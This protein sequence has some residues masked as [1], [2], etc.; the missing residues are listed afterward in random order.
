MW[1]G[2]EQV[3]DPTQQFEKG[4]IR[5][6]QEERIRVQQKTFT[7]WINFH[8]K[9]TGIHVEDLFEDIRNGRMLHQLLQVISGEML[10]KV[11]R[12]VMRIQ[13][14]ENVGISLSFLSKKVTLENIGASD[15]VDGN[16][17][18]IL[19][20]I[21][22]IILRFQIQQIVFE[23]QIVQETAPEQ[24]SSVKKSAKESLLLWCQKQ[25]E[26]YD[27]V[28]IRNFDKSWQDGLAFN[29]LLHSRRPDLVNYDSLDPNNAEWNLRHAF[30]SAENEMNIPRLIDPE[31]VVT[32]PDEKSI[33]TYVAQIYSTYAKMKAEKRSGRRMENVVRM[34]M[35]I[36]EAEKKYVALFSDLVF[37]VR[38]K[39]KELNNR[40]FPNS[41]T[42]IQEHLKKFNRY[43]N[44]EKPMKYKEKG[45]LHMMFHSINVKCFA[46]NRIPFY[47]PEGH[48][49][50]NLEA[51]WDVLDR[52]ERE[53]ERAIV[54]EYMRLESLER[55]A[56]R[57]KRKE[58]LRMAWLEDMWEIIED[59]EQCRDSLPVLAA[60]Q[61]NE[62]IL[63]DVQ[64]REEKFAK[65]KELAKFLW[66]SDYHQK[67]EIN[68]R[69]KKLRSEYERLRQSVQAAHVVLK[70]A[71]DAGVVARQTH[72]IRQEIKSIEPALLSQETGSHLLMV[73]D[74]LRRHSMLEGQIVSIDARITQLQNKVNNVVAAEHS[75]SEQTVKS[76]NALKKDFKFVKERS[77]GR[78]KA[79]EQNL[80]LFQFHQDADEE[81]MWLDESSQI[82]MQPVVARDLL[83]VIE[84]QKK[85][86][87]FEQKINTHE[88]FIKDILKRGKSLLKIP[89]SFGVQQRMEILPKKLE[90]LKSCSSER[91]ERLQE[92][93]E[94]QQ[95]Y[96]DANDIES[97]MKE[98]Y[99][100]VSN[101]NYGQDAMSATNLFDAHKKL[102][103]QI[104]EFA[105][106]VS[107]LREDADR[108]KK[109]EL[110]LQPMSGGVESGVADEFIE[111]EVYIPVEIEDREMI[112]REIDHTDTEV[113]EIPRVATLREY[114][115]KSGFIIKAGTQ[116]DLQDSSDELFWVVKDSKTGREMTLP[117]NL[118]R[119]N[120]TRHEEVHVSKVHTVHEEVAV[121]RIQK[122]KQKVK[123]RKTL[124]TGISPMLGEKVTKSSRF[125]AE[126]IQLRQQ[127]IESTYNQ[128]QKL[129]SARL[130][131]LHDFA[132]LFNFFVGAEEL[133]TWI[134]I[135]D[136]WIRS[137]LNQKKDSPDSLRHVLETF[138]TE[139]VANE[140]RV[141][142]ILA[143][144]EK[145]ARGSV[146]ASNKRKISGM[147]SNI[148][149]KW[150]AL[151]KLKLE[152]EKILAGAA[153][154]NAFEADMEGAIDMAK[155]TIALLES[156]IAA[157]KNP[158]AASA[159]LLKH[160]L[161]PEDV[162]A[163]INKLNKTIKPL[164]ERINKLIVLGNSL[165]ST[166]PGQAALVKK[167]VAELQAVRDNLQRLLDER[168]G[169]L[170]REK[171]LCQFKKD[172]ESQISW[173]DKARDIMSYREQPSDLET[174]SD[175]L[176]EHDTL[177]DEIDFRVPVIEEL[178]KE[179]EALK[180]MAGND[181]DFGQL[182]QKVTQLP[183]QLKNEW[184]GR[185]KF[186]KDCKNAAQFYR[187]ADGV[188]AQLG[189]QLALLSSDNLGKSADEVESLLN[190]LN[191]QK[192]KIHLLDDKTKN[193]DTKAAK[194]TR[195]RNVASNKVNEK[196]KE[197]KSLRDKT[198]KAYNE[199][200]RSLQDSLDYQ[201]LL[202]DV[203]E[204][205][206][207]MLERLAI[208]QDPAF[209]E[210]VNLDKKQKIIS[211]LESE[212][213][214]RHTDLN[215]IAERGKHLM[216]Q[217]H[218][219]SPEI[220]Q[221]LLNLAK[222][223]K[224][225]KLAVENAGG[226]IGLSHKQKVLRDDIK[227]RNERLA[228]LE[229]E[230]VAENLGNSLNEAKDLLK[231]NQVI[232]EEIQDG[233]DDAN[234][235]LLREVDTLIQK[236]HH[237]PDGIRKMLS[238]YADSVKNLQRRGGE[239]NLKLKDS[240]EFFQWKE[241]ALSQKE[242][243][244][245]R[246]DEAESTHFGSHLDA[247][248]NLLTRHQ[249]LDQELSD[250][251]S[252]VKELLLG[253][254]K[255]IMANHWAKEQ[256]ESI[257]D[258]ITF[259]WNTINA[260]CVDRM[261]N[262]QSVLQY[263]R[264][265]MSLEDALEWVDERLSQYHSRRDL[266]SSH[267]DK[268]DERKTANALS[269][270]K[271]DEVA[272][273]RYCTTLNDLDESCN[274]FV[275][276]EH[277]LCES[278]KA[279]QNELGD[280]L[281]NLTDELKTGGKYFEA[282]QMAA[283]F[284]VESTELCDWFVEAAHKA[285]SSDF[286][287]DFES[288]EK[289]KIDFNK[290]KEAV[291]MHK[292]NQLR[293]CEQLC[294]K[295]SR[296]WTGD[297]FSWVEEKLDD[298][299]SMMN[300]LEVMVSEREDMMESAGELHKFNLDVVEALSQIQ[301]KQNAI[302]TAPLANPTL[303]GVQKLLRNHESFET[304]LVALEAQLHALV[305]ESDRLSQ[306][307]PG[308]NE[309]SLLESKNIMVNAWQNLK[310]DSAKRKQ[311]L[312]LTLEFQKYKS[313]AKDLIDW[314]S[315]QKRVVSAIKDSTPSAD[316]MNDLQESL[317]GVKSGLK[318]KEE[319]FK[320]LVDRSDRMI[321]SEE[322]YPVD[323][324][325]TDEQID[326]VLNTVLSGK[327]ALEDETGYLDA[328]ITHQTQFFAFL[329]KYKNLK[330]LMMNETQILNSRNSRKVS[331]HDP[332]GS[333]RE[334][335]ALENKISK[336][337][338]LLDDIRKVA[339]ELEMSGHPKVK[340]V[341]ALVSELESTRYQV[342]AKCQARRALLD[343]TVDYMD[344]NMRAAEEE[345]WLK[346]KQ[347]LADND[348]YKKAETFEQKIKVLQKHQ[349]LE[350]EIE[351]GKDRFGILKTD[352]QKV[353]YPGPYA[354]D[355]KS[356]V[357]KLEVLWRKLLES[358]NQKNSVLSE[359]REVVKFF[360]ECDES[361]KWLKQKE[362]LLKMRDL[363][364]DYE[365]CLFILDKLNK[366]SPDEITPQKLKELNKLADSI[367]VKGQLDPQAV[368]ERKNEINDRYQKVNRDMK[369]YTDELKKSLEVHKFIRDS[370]DLNDL[371]AERTS[372]AKS[373]DVGDSL[374]Y[375]Q[376]LLNR[377]E[378]VQKT[379]IPELSSKM[380]NL[381]A[382]GLELSHRQPAREQ[383]V[384]EA[385]Q[386]ANSNWAVLNDVTAQRQK[387]LKNSVDCFTFLH[388]CALRNKWA[389]ELIDSMHNRV[390]PKNLKE[391]DNNFQSHESLNKEIG[392][393]GKDVEVLLQSG[394]ELSSKVPRN[395]D[396]ISQASSEVRDIMH[397]LND[398]WGKTAKEL[399]D[400]IAYQQFLKEAADCDM[401]ITNCELIFNTS[402]VG[403]SLSAVESLLSKYQ[404]RVSAYGEVK[405]Q[406]NECI[407]KGEEI[408]ENG[409]Y[410]SPR[411][412]SRMEELKNKLRSSGESCSRRKDRLNVSK[413]VQLFLQKTRKLLLWVADQDKKALD[414]NFRDP[415]NLLHKIELHSTFE[416]GIKQHGKQ[417]DDLKNTGE[418]LLA[419]SFK[420]NEGI[421]SDE[422]NLKLE[423]EAKIRE[424]LEEWQMLLDHSGD[425]KSKLREAL[426]AVEFNRLAENVEQFADECEKDFE[427]N[428]FGDNL[429]S[430]KRV[431]AK[432]EKMKD[433]LHEKSDNV[434]VL[435]D[436]MESL[437]VSTTCP[438]TA[439][440]QRLDDIV[441]RYDNLTQGA[442]RRDDQL[443]SSLI[444]QTFIEK[445]NAHIKW[446]DQKMLETQF[447][448]DWTKD[449]STN[450]I[451]SMLVAS[452]NL[453]KE[454]ENSQETLT[455]LE[456]ESQILANHHPVH[457]NT[458]RQSFGSY[459][460][461]F[462]RLKQAS[463]DKTNVLRIV[464]TA[465]KLLTRTGET[466]NWLAQKEKFLRDIDSQ[467]FVRDEQS[468]QNVLDQVVHF[469]TEM[470]NQRANLSQ[471]EEDIS[472]VEKSEI[473]P[474]K[475]MF[476]NLRVRPLRE[477]LEELYAYFDK[478]QSLY[479][480]RVVILT[481][482]LN[483]FLFLV[484][485]EESMDELDKAKDVCRNDDYGH[486]VESVEILVGDFRGK[487]KEMI[488]LE[489]SCDHLVQT[490]MNLASEP[491]TLPELTAKSGEL[492]A[493]CQ[494]LK[495]LR[496][497]RAAALE[498]ARLVHKL[499]RDIEDC[500]ASIQ[501]KQAELSNE[502]D[503][504]E[505]ESLQLM[506]DKQ[507]DLE[508]EIE[509][510]NE[511]VNK[512][513]SNGENLVE[514]YG[515]DD[516]VNGKVNELKAEWTKLKSMSGMQNDKL[517][518]LEN[519][520]EFYDMF[521]E[522]MQWI[523]ETITTMNSDDLPRDVPGATLK[524]KQ[525]DLLKQNIRSKD[526]DVK[527]LWAKGQQ[528]IETGVSVQEDIHEKRCRV[529]DGY[530][531]VENTWKQ[532]SDLYKINLDL[533][534][535]LA[536]V[537]NLD[538][539]IQKKTPEVSSKNCGND[540]IEVEDLLKKQKELEELIDA[541][542]EKIE[543]INRKTKLES[544]LAD[545]KEREEERAR[546]E[547]RRK[548]QASIRKRETTRI[549]D[550]RHRRNR[551]Q[552]RRTQE[553]AFSPEK[554][555]TKAV[556][557]EAI[558]S[559]ESASE[560]QKASSFNSNSNQDKKFVS[561][562][563]TDY[564]MSAEAAQPLS[565]ASGMNFESGLSK[566]TGENESGAFSSNP[567]PVPKAP[568]I[569]QASSLSKQTSK[570]HNAS[571]P[572]SGA[573]SPRR[574][575]SGNNAADGT[576]VSSSQGGSTSPSIK[577]SFSPPLSP[578]R[579]PRGSY[580]MQSP[581]LEGQAKIEQ[582][583][584]SMK[585][586]F[587][588]HRMK[589]I[590]ASNQGES[591]LVSPQEVNQNNQ[592]P[593]DAN[594]VHR[595]PSQ[596]S[597]NSYASINSAWSTA[598]FTDANTDSSSSLS[599]SFTGMVERK[600][601]MQS[602]SRKA[603][604]R[605]WKTLYC[606]V[607]SHS[608]KFYKDEH[609][610]RN[611]ETCSSLISLENAICEEAVDYHKKKHT[612]R[613]ITKDG[614]EY[615]F[616]CKNET[617]ARNLMHA[618]NE[619]A[620]RISAMKSNYN[621]THS[622]TVMSGYGSLERPNI[623]PPQPPSSLGATLEPIS[624]SSGLRVQTSPISSQKSQTNSS[625]SD[626]PSPP[627]TFSMLSRN[628]LTN[629]SFRKQNQC[630]EITQSFSSTSVSS[631]GAFAPPLPPK[632]F[633]GQLNSTSSNSWQTHE[634]KE[635][636]QVTKVTS[637]NAKHTPAIITASNKLASI[638]HGSNAVPLSPNLQRSNFSQSYNSGMS[639]NANKNP[640]FPKS[641]STG[642]FS[643]GQSS[644]TISLE[645]F[646]DRQSSQN[647][648]SRNLSSIP[649][650]SFA[651]MGE[652]S[653]QYRNKLN[654]SYESLSRMG[655]YPFYEVPQPSSNI[656]VETSLDFASAP[657]QC[658]PSF[659][660]KQYLS[661]NFTQ[662]TASNASSHTIAVSSLSPTYS[663][664]KSMSNGNNNY[665]DED[666]R[667]IYHHQQQQHRPSYSNQSIASMSTVNPSLP[668]RFDSMGRRPNSASQRPSPPANPPNHNLNEHK[669][670]SGW[671][672]EA[673][674]TANKPNT[675]K[676]RPSFET[677][678]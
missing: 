604:M 491:G 344:F 160:K 368:R 11:S 285:Q 472:E 560:A 504:D 595:T 678:V 651:E 26:P 19:G 401:A 562:F 674:S 393:S 15:I 90:D 669:Q 588:T 225:L 569:R 580:S 479:A 548:L 625:A 274:E 374:D 450:L 298:L 144:G 557:S 193:L 531:V 643:L 146:G 62:A 377:H 413:E 647:W 553:I 184:V 518:R 147:T 177:K 566:S 81:E 163:Q 230:I 260:A 48:L 550:E 142:R 475:E 615:L 350:S 247:T 67:V 171:K 3:L 347:I 371:I 408:V 492:K 449:N 267:P 45:E 42:G 56:E 65:A 510:L 35:S 533:Q 481:T 71:N 24:E 195:D 60:F 420:P 91:L 354:K 324:V 262:L 290:L 373:D 512:L 664:G 126:N 12:G 96:T 660:N 300:D 646:G 356:T 33:M 348:D 663:Y 375:A 197:V 168:L 606:V 76:Y 248:A 120:G 388:N 10:P 205:D 170:E 13:Q 135:K 58:R 675:A 640:S 428:D 57:F 451:D 80:E 343:A 366:P 75:D 423:I 528:L 89:N 1:V 584:M 564:N 579:S 161:S 53:L 305:E 381:K 246:M 256:I 342:L 359:A 593:V 394:K 618:I 500:R 299:N 462:D 108:L 291:D 265:L 49:I 620:D 215:E 397:K 254:Q 55:V 236:G 121:K 224:D 549:T 536:D 659:D 627:L 30:D 64:A 454:L 266:I 370:N 208:A 282:C 271:T 417:V 234:G 540:L 622:S 392:N 458:L 217:Q 605:N 41:L 466:R 5:G 459:K 400:D 94:T 485:V 650:A 7:K 200:D 341:N 623:P 469:E 349:A 86:K 223:W 337:Q 585:Q 429:R 639:S 317:N 152:K 385:L 519:V 591:N 255:M 61:R 22:T 456:T 97:W 357:N 176:A 93:L 505:Y 320:T 249:A 668:R 597:G 201:T 482:Q 414:E 619:E 202:R 610:F 503:I 218:Y 104:A 598:R 412:E 190:Q 130:Q 573:A 441:Q 250:R 28:D 523:N 332:R 376:K 656:A 154:L 82:M 525:H 486:D 276:T 558:S 634:V 174:V 433:K 318:N 445:L 402:N 544:G 166:N 92:A 316:S 77:N 444:V 303:Q 383:E 404:S 309:E 453:D 182:G 109:T 635:S 319:D 546:D 336:E 387:N 380:E 44:E 345:S 499:N 608:I 159:G 306:V 175:A 358:L 351:N 122:R 576:N 662:D 636:F 471:T 203:S 34:L 297:D 468:C 188:E 183:I 132:D 111:E 355:C 196:L 590:E 213:E 101:D 547:H 221:A 657:S 98:K 480:K 46:N 581:Q 268:L 379:T 207:W 328:S 522:V 127:T 461:K 426:Q 517:K 241:D 70:G 293:N 84:L 269:N 487:E 157:S 296:T 389:M 384:F 543:A 398:V 99:P 185:D 435:L 259:L 587:S 6:L 602:G 14:L 110:A 151:K 283:E 430:V 214:K 541:Q 463:G 158:D 509:N 25:V 457:R 119:D 114:K 288:F 331:L 470:K 23:E 284:Q 88:T 167:K 295:I 338:V 139:L 330:Q 17:R 164:D 501:D 173:A 314:M 665:T 27:N 326:Q 465:F 277:P 599:P 280:Q 521:A 613:L 431:T 313:A 443:E 310:R 418:R 287:K 275:E 294:S 240:V 555:I 165:A 432:H 537:E 118:L 411:I 642:N 106:D 440:Q 561:P 258:E 446:T 483:Q 611:G 589:N 315:E 551:E 245:E 124:K 556:E 493:S 150:G 133:L 206:D 235:K 502:H 83:S 621:Q 490:G 596:N 570:L 648:S 567:I 498:G 616:D 31:D 327:S 603:T 129:S 520:K 329:S 594:N 539:W 631:K 2:N 633:R 677:Q 54:K 204:M 232:E 4:R 495:A 29:A 437:N 191:T 614:G 59:Q 626:Q 670:T 672:T 270:H 410:L 524:V 367:V 399:H 100:L 395:A 78:R 279:K 143:E 325:F 40:T 534:E 460:V 629:G 405:S 628:T 363:G 198:I 535:F 136:R 323:E 364:D 87:A 386:K 637:F 242:W 292:S 545:W 369:T 102:N 416:S 116:Y 194:M 244:Q 51:E 227:H 474:N 229:D 467:R 422:E 286:G 72:L 372:V 304:G 442:K 452:E 210:M 489:T 228:E 538:S 464:Q 583:Q 353:I 494:E 155:D 644:N 156:G 497:A 257:G 335:E 189:A 601:V 572:S 107:K 676:P 592:Q 311:N 515:N 307:Y 649:D 172:C 607:V 211:N 671:K 575:M 68:K 333:V 180:P 169:Q 654:S 396:K 447:D 488:S 278:I 141:A 63:L 312:L 574:S 137:E 352:A 565:S 38:Q 661:P 382:E 630:G 128:L 506:Y 233:C 220:R 473:L 390:L 407:K 322:I 484:E 438:T 153:G 272:V 199:R 421:L 653:A 516:H 37:W 131:M 571:N 261:S 586:A 219:A 21:W 138:L 302:P 186:L 20:L 222:R 9:P 179:S 125:D 424:L 526:A 117:K 8:L 391:A 542:K 673:P 36:D 237:D 527:A 251:E 578:M 513:Q 50:K 577:T 32:R 73:E 632:Q 66:T 321:T 378:L 427:S 148:Q 559:L 113:R 123:R 264:L 361:E 532:R 238:D 362:V 239:K 476:L 187:E 16:K 79:L 263:H 47:P 617:N 339:Q 346:E 514:R 439:M 74:L 655:D 212:L 529:Q 638:T 511:R 112:A 134:D 253:A 281:E 360:N 69:E 340:E 178:I 140:P 666:Q 658:N 415:T 409:N 582:T 624:S 103:E 645:G 600:A 301:E 403:D 477:R 95:Y 162:Q 273:S 530:K 507:E 231:E 436:M 115:D 181:R 308:E 612:L 334:Q 563:L 406:T 667:Q 243:F 39:T 209:K 652:S 192:D 425:K 216:N 496:E 226:T 419:E 455:N 609:A 478:V 508:K 149:A 641:T 434:A 43:R 568:I 85:Q 145:V 18:L 105:T 52:A 289:V 448:F 365:Q 552:R 554:I 252:F